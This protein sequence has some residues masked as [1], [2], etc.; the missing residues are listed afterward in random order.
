MTT[1]SYVGF[2]EDFLAYYKRYASRR[3]AWYLCP[4]LDDYSLEETVALS[5]Y[6]RLRQTIHRKLKRLNQTLG[7]TRSDPE[8]TLNCKLGYDEKGRIKFLEN[9]I[10]RNK[11]VK[12]NY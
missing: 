11:H 9:L 2:L 5:H 10:K 1:K 4:I 7:N 3:R 12:V 8:Y 6:K